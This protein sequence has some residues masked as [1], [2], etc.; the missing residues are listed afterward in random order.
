MYDCPV[1][2]EGIPEGFRQ[3]MPDKVTPG[4]VAAGEVWPRATKSH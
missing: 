1:V 3:G 2:P 4:G